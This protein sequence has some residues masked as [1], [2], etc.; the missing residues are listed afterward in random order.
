MIIKISI[1]VINGPA[2]KEKGRS[3]TEI[4]KIFRYNLFFL[5]NIIKF[6][7]SKISDILDI[8]YCVFL[9]NNLLKF[10]NQ[11]NLKT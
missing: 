1:S 11:F 2:I 10:Y 7:K 5:V 6:V 4:N 8:I 3:K 9:N